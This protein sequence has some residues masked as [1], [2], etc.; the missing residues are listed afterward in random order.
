MGR[1]RFK[2]P[3]R[4]R[5]LVTGLVENWTESI[6]YLERLATRRPKMDSS[7]ICELRTVCFS[8]SFSS[9]RSFTEAASRLPPPWMRSS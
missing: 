8:Y 2:G 4:A 7:S 3:A 1:F 5:K 6:A 9:R